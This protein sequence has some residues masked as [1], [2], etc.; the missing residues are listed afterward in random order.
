MRR[1]LIGATLGGVV[2]MGALALAQ[3]T[4]LLSPSGSA[5]TAVGGKWYQDGSDAMFYAGGKWIEVTYGRPVKR[6]R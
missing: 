4:R 6:G 5:A 1:I 2:A 3:G